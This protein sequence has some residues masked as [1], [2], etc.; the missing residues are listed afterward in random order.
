V[1]GKDLNPWSPEYGTSTNHSVSTF[2]SLTV[3]FQ[4]L[5]RLEELRETT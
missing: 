5:L 2:G 3:F 1:L 4:L